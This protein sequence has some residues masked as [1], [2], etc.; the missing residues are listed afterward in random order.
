MS[1]FEYIYLMICY[2]N[3][4]ILKIII[5]IDMEFLQLKWMGSV[6]FEF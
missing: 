2:K 3:N 5:S 4:F 6:G 1:D